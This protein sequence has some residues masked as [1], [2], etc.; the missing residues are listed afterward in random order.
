MSYGTLPEAV[1]HTSSR[2]MDGGGCVAIARERRLGVH[3]G[4]GR[5]CVVP[6]FDGSG[7][8]GDRDVHYLPATYAG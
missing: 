6:G 4:G 5:S 8:L 1:Y 7:N 2:G 3:G